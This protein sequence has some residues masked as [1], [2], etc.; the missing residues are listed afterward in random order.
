MSATRESPKMV[1]STLIHILMAVSLLMAGSQKA[2][3]SESEKMP[4]G[5]GSRFLVLN[6]CDDDNILKTA[7]YGDTVYIMDSRGEIIRVVARGLTVK[8]ECVRLSVSE[9]GR[10][11]VICDGASNTLTVYEVRTGRKLWSLL[12]LFNS[13]AFANSL[14]YAS[15]GDSI[16]AI[17]RTGT[18]VKHVR[19]EVFDMVVDG[20]GNC[21][22]I[23]GIDIKKCNLDLEL[24]WEVNRIRGPLGP[25]TSYLIGTNPGGSIWIA[26]Q[27][28]YRQHGKNNRLVKVSSKG[29]IY[30]KTIPL[31]FRPRCVRVDK[32]NGD[33]WVTGQVEGP[34]DF[35]R[36]GDEWPDTLTELNV[37]TKTE[38]EHFT[39]KYDSKGKLLLSIPI[40]GSS[41]V[42][43][44]FDSS[45][46]ITGKRNIAHFSSE[47]KMLGTHTGD[48][49]GRKLLALV[50]DR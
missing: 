49:D 8:S 2:F 14:V 17:D 50:P 18:I 15:S 41:V 44:P 25:W 9:D 16:Y 23:S 6:D 10:L 43:D 47:G 39:Q 24:V 28:A 12:G 20:T 26:Q 19:M 31:E 33:V 11:F 42:V 5:I 7:P 38:I 30:N 29:G 22:W 48:S 3:T 40:S 45:I 21:L 1:K 27:D 4:D 46:W 36:I 32:T 34:R 13:A 37:L 35:S